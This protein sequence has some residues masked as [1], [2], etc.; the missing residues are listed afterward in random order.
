MSLGFNQLILNTY[1]VFVWEG[2]IIP[3]GIAQVDHLF[4]TV[5]GKEHT[6][7]TR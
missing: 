4:V 3:L 2:S 7:E 6:N 5:E 1:P